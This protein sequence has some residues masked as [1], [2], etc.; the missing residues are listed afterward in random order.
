MTSF[1]QDVY[2][3]ATQSDL[4]DEL[5]TSIQ[6]SG[7]GGKR[8]SGYGTFELEIVDLPEGLEGLLNNGGN[9]QLLL[10][11]SLPED[12]ELVHAM[13]GARYQLVKRSGFAYS[14]TASQLLRKQDLYKFKAGS[15]FVN[16]FKGQI[17]DVSPY[18]YPHPVY[19][20]SKGLFL[21]LKGVRDNE[22]LSY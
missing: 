9:E 14:E 19:N 6:Y 12:T 1:N 13:T 5:M 10:T 11:T 8:S 15:V 2:V 3:L 7:L 22:K 20:F 21:D 17:S 18:N 16:K 4:F